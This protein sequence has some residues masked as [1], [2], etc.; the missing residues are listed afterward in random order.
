MLFLNSWKLLKFVVSLLIIAIA[1]WLLLH[2]YA[3]LGLFIALA[4]PFWWFFLQKQTVCFYCATHEEGQHC[5][6]CKRTINKSTGVFP[7]TFTSAFFN[8]SL[9]LVLFLFA[10]GLVYFE[11]NLLTYAGFR[12]Y[13]PRTVSFS[14]PEKNQFS[15][16]EIFPLYIELRNIEVPVNTVRTDLRFD[17]KMLEV[18]EISTKESFANIFVQK[19]FDNEAG[20]VRLA[21]GLPNPGFDGEGGLFG[22]VYFK[23]LKTGVVKVEYLP[24]SM[25]LAND[26]KGTNVLKDLGSTSYIIVNEPI[27]DEKSYSKMDLTLGPDVLGEKRTVQME[28]YEDK[29]SVLGATAKD[30]GTNGADALNDETIYED[31][32][33]VSESV[34]QK[35]ALGDVVFSVLEWFD[36]VVI[37]FWSDVF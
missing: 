10:F 14:I 29:S 1:S 36:K 32:S 34:S 24:T 37:G 12:L 6:L 35:K 2:L 23:A 11:G 21:G 5:P 26:G 20:Y 17:P 16:D 22:T 19:E 25:V 4:Y 3:L 9:L 7:E 18:T 30:A 28:F 8:S 31:V 27:M 13:T 15:I 33:E